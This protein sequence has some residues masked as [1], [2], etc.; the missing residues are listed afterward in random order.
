MYIQ[1]YAKKKIETKGGWVKQNKPLL[2]ATGKEYY[3]V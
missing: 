1:Q 2:T 3:L